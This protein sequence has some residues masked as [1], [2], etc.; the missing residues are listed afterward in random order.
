MLAYAEYKLDK[1]EWMQSNPNASPQETELFL[2][3]YT[4]RILN[5]YRIDA[6]NVLYSY[7]ATYAENQLNEHLSELKDKGLSQELK[8]AEVSLSRSINATKV[9]FIQSI[10]QNIVASAIFG[11]FLFIGALFIR[12]AA[13]NSSAG[14]LLQ[15][16]FAPENYELRVI[17]KK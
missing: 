5:K 4:D 15:Y 14:Q 10:W 9:S 6:E 12:F 16:L 13:P 1:Y 2:T 11:F 3:H 17:E 8:N 7:A